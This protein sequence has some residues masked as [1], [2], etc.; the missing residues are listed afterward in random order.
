MA[1]TK[2]HTTVTKFHGIRMDHFMMG[3]PS[4]GVIEI[5]IFLSSCIAHVHSF[6][7]SITVQSWSPKVFIVNLLNWIHL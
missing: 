7:S 6:S 2:C 4:V 3:V 5:L 1:S